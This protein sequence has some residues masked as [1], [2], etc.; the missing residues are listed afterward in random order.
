LEDG[1]ETLNPEV[2]HSQAS[3][4]LQIMRDGILIPIKPAVPPVFRGSV[5]NTE[6]DVLGALHIRCAPAA[7]LR[8]QHG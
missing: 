3:D 6:A 7:Y 8:A 4:G 5:V 2:V 1:P